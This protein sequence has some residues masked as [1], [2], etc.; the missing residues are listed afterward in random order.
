MPPGRRLVAVPALVVATMAVSALV[1]AGAV[2]S[3]RVEVAG[4]LLGDWW[5]LLSSPFVCRDVAYAAVV[6]TGFALF[7]SLLERRAGRV[8]ILSTWLAAG[9]LAVWF[10]S[11]STIDPAGGPIAAALAVTVAWIAAELFARRRGDADGDLVGAAV[12]LAVL[13]LLPALV[14]QAAWAALPAGL[15]IGFLA[16]GW[17]ILRGR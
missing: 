6:L 9:S 11:A 3:A 13:L 10:C 17:L 14:P 12:S 15:G 5:K 1:R 4:P 16:A 7:G 8:F 2:K